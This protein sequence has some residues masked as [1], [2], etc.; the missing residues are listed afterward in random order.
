MEKRN[1]DQLPKLL[2][3][4]GSAGSLSVLLKV[5]PE[6]KTTITICIVIVIH[7]KNTSDS[8]LRKLFST[9]TFLPVKEI[10]DKEKLLCGTIYIAPPDYHILFENDGT[11]ALDYSEKV[12]Y[13]R[14]SIDVAFESASQEYK[15]HLT[16]IL[17]SGASS[18]GAKGLIEV[19]KN[20]GRTVVQDPLTAEASY[21]PEQAINALQPDEI[22]Y[23]LQMI[24]YINEL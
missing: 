2:V 6:I 23:P 21:M 4:G 3:I 10:E 19:K 8:T 7:R 20:E 18:D 15:K 14:P 9:K 13:S 12:N 1:I 5:L 22:L 24:A 17:L 11:V 16:C